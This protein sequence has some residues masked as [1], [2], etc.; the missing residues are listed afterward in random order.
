MDFFNLLHE[1][2]K[3]KLNNEQKHAVT[4]IKGPALVL[5][6]P[7]SG[8]TTVITSRTAYLILE[9]G[10]RP[11]NILTMTF[12][13][14]AKIEMEQRFNRI[15]GEGTGSK[16]HFSTL[17]SFCNLVV[18]DYEKRQGK[19]LRR[20]EGDEETQY[21]KRIILKD[22]Y[23]KIN[24]SKIN[25]DELEDLINAIGLAKNKMIKDLNDIDINMKNFPEIYKAYEEN[26]KANLFMDFDDMLSYSHSILTKCP[27]ILN[28]YIEKYRFIQVD[29]GQDLSKIQFE[30]LKLLTKSDEKN[31]FIV[32]DDDQS[33]YGFRGAEPKYILEMERRYPGCAY[34]YLTNNYRSTANIVYISSRFIK[35]NNHRY[36]KNHCTQNEFIHDPIIVSTRDEN[37]QLQFIIDK[38]NEHQKNKKEINIALLYRNNLSSIP[39]AEVLDRNGLEFNIKQNKLFFFNHWIVQDILSFF[40]F[41]LDQTDIESLTRIYY[42]MNRYISKA[43]LEHALTTDYK[44]SIIDGILTYGDI[45]P[46]SKKLISDVKVEF[47]RLSKKRPLD[48]LNYI[49]KGF[50][51]FD[52]VKDYC[53]NTGLYF[54]FLYRLFGVLKIIA[55]NYKTIPEFLQRVLEIQQIL[56]APKPNTYKK[57]ITLS[58]IHSSKGLEYD[59]VMMVDL[60]NSEFP[61]ENAI[62]LS[63]EADTKEHLEEERRLFYVG[64]TR[65]KE[66]IYLIYPKSRNGFIEERTIFIEE[67]LN[68][69]KTKHL[70]E[71]TEGIIVKHKY[72]GQGV[73]VAVL[74]EKK[75]SVVVEIDFKG[76]RRKLDLA[77]CVESGLLT[78]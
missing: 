25:D 36:D 6:G 15:F 45:K 22:I 30:I 67:I 54:E 56:E 46:Y 73:V 26:K 50:N 2:Y 23:N 77:T 57:T 65:A 64:I 10:V 62:E 70:S 4:H 28:K 63:K 8:K 20:I 3:I 51:Y 41:S 60:V 37:Y 59:C 48:G 33:I 9:V 7:G 61:G 40:R 71:I 72:F 14:A 18:R 29:E 76:A 75:N 31:I 5:A 11:E 12:N 66:Y 68:C 44:D 38:I 19:R 32:A 21:S 39:L 49:E 74:E 78:F 17:H 16:V 24:G 52:Y 43:M 34:F 1:N 13:R 58:T 35:E 42:K 27:D 55:E 53:E 47:K 69:I